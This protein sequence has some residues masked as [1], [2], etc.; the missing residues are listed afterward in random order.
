MNYIEQINLFNEYT[1]YHYLPANSQLIWYKLMHLFNESSWESE[2][3]VDNYRLMGE[4]S[5]KCERTLNKHREFLVR[6]GLIEYTPGSG[7]VPS[8]Y[9]L[10]ELYRAHGGTVSIRRRYNTRGEERVE[11]VEP[12]IRKKDS[13]QNMEINQQRKITSRPKVD[14]P[15]KTTQVI[16]LFNAHHNQM[17]SV[18]KRT[19]ERSK[20][21]NRLFKQGYTMDDFETVFLNAEESNFLNGFNDRGWTAD[22]DWLLKPKNFVKVLEGNYKN[23][24]LAKQEPTAQ[25]FLD[26]VARGI[27]D[28]TGEPIQE[29][30]SDFVVEEPEYVLDESLEGIVEN[31]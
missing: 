18:R 5:I 28:F 8:T 25:D 23:K 30:F 20:A 15:S 31:D 11:D 12:K 24:S 1:R 21:V 14:R 26:G 19:T 6:S 13:Y 22:F 9:K 10:N 29:D 27:I 4:T 7:H 16:D 3:H 2:I 17:R